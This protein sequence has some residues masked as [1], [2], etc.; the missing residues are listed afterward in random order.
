LDLR[1]EIYWSDEEKKLGDSIIYEFTKGADFGTLLLSERF[2]TQ[3]GKFDKK[4][5]EFEHKTL[6]K[7]INENPL[8][9]FYWS[10]KPLLDIPFKINGPVLDLRNVDLRIQLYIRSK[11]KICIGNQSGL[12][13]SI[14]RYTNLHMTQRQ[15]PIKHNYIE[16]EQYYADA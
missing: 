4:T 15:V 12:L 16:G 2:G 7:L 6:T 14:S 13:Q 8:F 11:G 5:F 9:Y 10:Y 1:P 3:C